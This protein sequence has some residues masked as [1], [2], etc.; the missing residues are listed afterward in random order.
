L[1]LFG[2]CTKQLFG[3]TLNFLEFYNQLWKK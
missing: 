3:E 1:A 2:K